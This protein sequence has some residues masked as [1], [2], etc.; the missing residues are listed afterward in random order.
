MDYFHWIIS[1]AN[2]KASLYPINRVMLTSTRQSLMIIIAEF[3]HERAVNRFNF[4]T[5]V[6]SDDAACAKWPKNG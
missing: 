1:F 5:K 2:Y 6:I 3:T 4:R